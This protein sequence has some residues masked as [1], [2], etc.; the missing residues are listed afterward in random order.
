MLVSVNRG[1][2][3]RAASNHWGLIVWRR[4]ADHDVRFGSV[5]NVCA[6]KRHVRFTPNS[7]H[8]RRN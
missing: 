5:A 1:R 7:G 3:A 2:A 6:A 8:V 4:W